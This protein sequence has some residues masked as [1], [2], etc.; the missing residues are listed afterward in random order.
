MSSQLSAFTYIWNGMSSSVGSITITLGLI[1][2]AFF[3]VL[4]LVTKNNMIALMILGMPL[5]ILVSMASIGAGWV[6][7]IV[8]IFSIITYTALA[9]LLIR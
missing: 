9:R 8:I 4:A 7:Y 5:I 2:L 1:A 6:G 3:I